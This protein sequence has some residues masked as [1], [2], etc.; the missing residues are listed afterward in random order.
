[1]TVI[2]GWAFSS[3]EQWK[4][5]VLPYLDHQINRDLFINAEKVRADYANKNQFRGFFAS[6]NTPA[7]TYESLLG[8]EPVASQTG[9]KNTVIAPYAAYPM[10][11]ADQNQQTNTG[12]M[13][14]KN[15]L[16]YTSMLSEYGALESY[17]TTTYAT[18]PLLTWDGKAL[19]NLAM[20]GGVINLTREFMIKEGVYLDFI[21]LLDSQYS[22]LSH[23]I[24]GADL[25]IAAPLDTPIPVSPCVDSAMVVGVI[26]DFD[27]Q[28]LMSIAGV[29]IVENPNPITQNSSQFV[30]QYNDPAGPWD[31]LVVD[32]YS[33]IDLSNHAVFS[34]KVMA[35]VSG[36]LKAKLEGGQS[37]P[38]ELDLLISELNTWV[39][40]QFDFSAYANENHQ[41][42][43]V[44]FNAGVTNSGDDIYYIDDLTLVSELDN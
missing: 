7:N 10:L 1:L 20:T 38:V 37:V 14:L 5:L 12:L 22:S 26:S 4:F 9:V 42:I 34:I 29:P 36:V 30:G 31:A 33:P 32:Y 11:L 35:P 40:Y 2:E 6:V 18:A 16:A 41:K 3:H 27:C 28:K 24:S 13:W 21:N 39:D 44:F 25:S 43:A 15:T 17:H 19:P 23:Q 8:I